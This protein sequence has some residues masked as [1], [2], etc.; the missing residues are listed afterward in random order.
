MRISL[1]LAATGAFVAASSPA[2]GF[3]WKAQPLA[4]KRQMASQ[5]ISCMKKRMATDRLISYYQASKICRETIE[6]QIEKSSSGP[7]VAADTS[8]AK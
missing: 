4:V 6:G 1:I 2:F 5:M 3:D 8:A 7:L